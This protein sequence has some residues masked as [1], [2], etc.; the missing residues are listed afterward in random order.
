M[1]DAAVPALAGPFDGQVAGFGP[2][3]RLFARRHLHDSHAA[4][5]FAQ[6]VLMIVLEALRDGRVEDTERLGAFVLGTCRMAL[7][8]LRRGVRRRDELLRRF[9]ADLVPDAPA[10]PSLDTARLEQCLGKLG[11]Q[12]RA[13]L[14]LTFYADESAGEIAAELGLSAVNVRVSRHRALARLND[15]VRGKGGA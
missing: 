5:D 11:E 8:D 2:R 15:C 14:M 4:D 1:V 9:G 13:V 7:L 12:E 3:V 10:G 6:E